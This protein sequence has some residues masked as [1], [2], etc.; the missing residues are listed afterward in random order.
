MEL[1]LES[2]G[3]NHREELEKKSDQTSVNK[4]KNTIN[5]K[6]GKKAK[7]CK[8]EVKKIIRTRSGYN[9]FMQ[10]NLATYKTD[11]PGV[12]HK[13]AFRAVAEMWQ[14]KKKIVRP[15][16]EFNQFM[17]DNLDAYKRDHPGV[18]HKVA[19]CA[20]AGLWGA[21]NRKKNNE[22]NNK[23]KNND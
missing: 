15:R 6:I 10:E 14:Q 2:Q 3:I 13:T 23:E 11:H 22:D 1:F 8:K 18:D 19:F 21:Q 17:H 12:D 16:S 20:V 4:E 9:E 7:P 5:E